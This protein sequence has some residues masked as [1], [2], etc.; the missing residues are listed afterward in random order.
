MYIVG[1]GG[2][3]FKAGAVNW[4]PLIAGLFKQS[5]DDCD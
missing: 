4:E 2:T 5:I 3:C 1:C